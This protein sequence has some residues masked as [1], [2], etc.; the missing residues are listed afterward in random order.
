MP[1]FWDMCNVFPVL[2]ISYKQTH[3][4]LAPSKHKIVFGR[5]ANKLSLK[6]GNVEYWWIVIYKLE[7]INLQ[8]QAVIKFCLCSEKLHF[9]QY[10]S[11]PVIDLSIKHTLFIN[12]KVERN[13][14]S[15]LFVLHYCWLIKYKCSLILITVIC[16][17]QSYGDQQPAS[18]LCQLWTVSVHESKRSKLLTCICRAVFF[19]NDNYETCLVIHSVPMVLQSF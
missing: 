5:V 16:H 7:Q 1:F 8:C 13:W 6:E 3:L 12:V 19:T 11:Q 15:I 17:N 2:W 9:C 10:D 14:V 18:R 4:L